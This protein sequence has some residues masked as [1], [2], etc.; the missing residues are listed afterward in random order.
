MQLLSLEYGR[1]IKECKTSKFEGKNLRSRVGSQT[2]LPTFF[3]NLG[4]W[5]GTKRETYPSPSEHDCD[6]S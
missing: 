3:S 2:V 5:K 6:I 1:D 4:S